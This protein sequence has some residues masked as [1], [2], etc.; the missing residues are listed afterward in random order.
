MGGQFSDYL[1]WTVVCCVADRRDWPENG[2]PRLDLRR[3]GWPAY[4]SAVELEQA[5]GWVFDEFARLA[6]AEALKIK[7]DRVRHRIKTLRPQSLRTPESLTKLLYAPLLPPFLRSANSK[8]DDLTSGRT[9]RDLHQLLTD[10]GLLFGGLMRSGFSPSSED[11]IF[12]RAIRSL[13][14]W[15]ATLRFLSELKLAPDRHTLLLDDPD[16]NVIDSFNVHITRGRRPNLIH[17]ML[18]HLRQ[19]AR[20][21]LIL[22]TNFDTLI[23]D[24]FAGQ[25]RQIEVISVGTK[26][27]LPDPDLV[28]ARDIVV[29]LH[30]TASETRADFSL[31]DPPS[32]EDRK[33]FFSY[34][35]G[36]QADS[37]GERFIA[38]QLL[39]AR[40]SGLDARCVQL[41]K[42]VLDGDQDARIYWICNSPADEGR[43]HVL[44]RERAYRDRI[45]TTRTERVDLL[46]YELHQKLCL[47]LPPASASAITSTTTLRRR[48]GSGRHS[49]TMSKQPAR[50][51]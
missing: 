48:I 33:R 13:H 47:S 39:V 1:A 36:G 49:K 16:Q 44:F 2:G 24:A 4:P 3:T 9:Q 25:E 31:D 12:E 11:A 46:L 50:R 43:L 29:K 21:R 34:V 5:R 17:T 6:S 27:L 26:G 51:T 37:T 40:Y 8:L 14:D 45:F 15:R 23:E 42:S 7:A 35:R 41:M 38:S 30:G 28:H 20:M 10:R 32:I 18:C 22:T 19:P